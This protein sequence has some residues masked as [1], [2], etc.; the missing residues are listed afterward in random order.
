[1]H[2][3]AHNFYVATRIASPKALLGFLRECRECATAYEYPP[4]KE[5]SNWYG[6]GPRYPYAIRSS[7]DLVLADEFSRCGAFHAESLFH[8]SRPEV[9]LTCKEILGFY[10]GNC[11]H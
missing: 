9:H 4:K 10:Y 5:A 7:L 6:V 3:L 11:M 2:I 8:R 1:M